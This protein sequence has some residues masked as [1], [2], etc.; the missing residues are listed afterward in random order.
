MKPDVLVI[1]WLISFALCYF[2]AMK[3]KTPKSVLPGIFKKLLK[4]GS[5]SFP[6]PAEQQKTFEKFCNHSFMDAEHQRARDAF[7]F[8][9]GQCKDLNID[10]VLALDGPVAA[11][12]YMIARG[13][14][15]NLITGQYY[16][17]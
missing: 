6:T 16:S 14:K 2:F 15:L 10:E 11:F 4:E 12:D 7:N 13:Y 17:P 1:L 3:P 5:I 9:F 8:I